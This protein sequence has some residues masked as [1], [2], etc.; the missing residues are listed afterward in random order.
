MRAYANALKTLADNPELREKY[1][2]AAKQRVI[3]KFTYREFKS[4][5]NDMICRVRKQN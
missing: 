1:G 2:I 5:I 3:D 4:R